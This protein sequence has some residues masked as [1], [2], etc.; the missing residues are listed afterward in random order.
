MKKTMTELWRGEGMAFRESEE[1]HRQV[2]QLVRELCQCEEELQIRP[3]SEDWKRLE[4]IQE[5]HGEMATLEKEDAFVRGMI[6]GIRLITEALG[7]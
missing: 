5:I 1:C 6:L 4:R 7:A 2:M 3:G